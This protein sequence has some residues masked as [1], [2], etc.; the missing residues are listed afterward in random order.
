GYPGGPNVPIDVAIVCYNKF[1]RSKVLMNTKPGRM[2]LCDNLIESSNLELDPYAVLFDGAG[3]HNPTSQDRADQGFWFERNNVRVLAKVPQPGFGS[4]SDIIK[5]TGGLT[6]GHVVGN[7]IDCLRPDVV[8]G[9]VDVF[10]GGGRLLFALNAMTNTNLHIKQSGGHGGMQDIQAYKMLRIID[11]DWTWT[12]SLA[13]FWHC[14]IFFRGSGLSTISGNTFDINATGRQV[15]AI[16]CD[17]IETNEDSGLGSA[18]PRH[19]IIGRNICQLRGRNDHRLLE[20]Q[21]PSG[22]GPAAYY[23]IEGN[24][25]ADPSGQSTATASLGAAHRSVIRGNISPHSPAWSAGSG[26]QVD[27]NIFR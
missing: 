9:Q 26:S 22:T 15:T 7:K 25:I 2:W 18:S 14:P 16:T 20:V 6:R 11:N 8:E 17:N 23:S 5:I 24:V 13:G 1:I 19:M 21:P 10:T 27:G 4:D 3:S 12:T